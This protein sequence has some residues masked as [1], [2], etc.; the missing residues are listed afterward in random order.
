MAS[1]ADKLRTK[2]FYDKLYGSTRVP[3]RTGELTPTLH[4]CMDPS[5]L[6]NPLSWPESEMKEGFHRRGR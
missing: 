4:N 3:Q 1:L 6:C 2:R 5:L